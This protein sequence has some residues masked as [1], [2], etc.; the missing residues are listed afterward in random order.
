MNGLVGLVKM[1]LKN[2]NK[3]FRAF[4]HPKNDDNDDEDDG[5]YG[6]GSGGEKRANKL[7]KTAC[8]TIVNTQQRS[9]LV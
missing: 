4:I 8:T 1:K 5:D 9:T 3:E 6:D 2:R 7:Q